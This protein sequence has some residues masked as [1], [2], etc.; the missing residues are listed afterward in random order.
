M[1][2]PIA[3]ILP[4]AGKSSRF[5]G[6]EKKPFTNIDGRAVWLRAAEHFVTRPEVKQCL[7]VVAAEDM[8]LF[9]RRF[10]ANVMF[11][12]IQ[13]VEGGK[14]RFESVA[15]AL[16]RLIDEIAL[17]AVHDAVR[18]CLP[19]VL[20]DN[21]FAAAAQ[22]GAAVPAL[23]AADTLK[24]VSNQM[25]VESTLSRDGVWNVQTPQVFRRQWIEEA[26]RRRGELTGPITDDA[27][28]VEAL[29]HPV[30]VVRGSPFNVKITT[31]EDLGMA[32]LFV[33]HRK[34][35]PPVKPARPFEDER[36]S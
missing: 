25:L 24:R 26:Y 16:S 20:I 29:G 11:L 32:E 28:L 34:F 19:S 23:P 15:N 6:K 21:I 7:V 22:H 27:Q 1:L 36:F 9:K 4:A 2:P 17:V 14:E 5:G 3:V 18:P 12:N 31:G 13:I 33:K 30:R 8:E 35:D 10:A